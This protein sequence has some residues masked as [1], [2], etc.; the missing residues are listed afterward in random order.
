MVQCQNFETKLIVT[1]WYQVFAT[2]ILEFREY[3]LI[4]EFNINSTILI[5]MANLY[6]V[7]ICIVSAI[8]IAKNTFC[9]AAL[10]NVCKFHFLGHGSIVSLQIISFYRA[11]FSNF[12]L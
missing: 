7:F 12:K 6:N 1:K 11:F 4:V 9:T 2:G 10:S 3:Y 5:W 8:I